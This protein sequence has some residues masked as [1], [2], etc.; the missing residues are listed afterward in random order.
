MPAQ[1]CPICKVKKLVGKHK[2]V[3]MKEYSIEWLDYE[4]ALLVVFKDREGRA[5]ILAG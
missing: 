3:C 5:K 1:L 4:H 2:E